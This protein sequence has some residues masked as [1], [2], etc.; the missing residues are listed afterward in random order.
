MVDALLRRECE[1]RYESRDL[2]VVWE[3]AEWF[4]AT[5]LLVAS[6]GRRS[7]AVAVVVAVVVVVLVDA[8]AAVFDGDG[9]AATLR[10]GASAASP[11]AAEASGGGVVRHRALA[12]I[13]GMKNEGCRDN[14]SSS[15]SSSSSSCSLPDVLCVAKVRC[16]DFLN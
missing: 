14:S 6:D 2:S 11:D 9:L 3:W 12:V 10:I 5:L 13:P 1:D 7:A 15:S 16:E 8:V 4:D